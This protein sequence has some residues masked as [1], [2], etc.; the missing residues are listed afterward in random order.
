MP[1]RPLSEDSLQLIDTLRQALEPHGEVLERPM[2][3]VYCLFLNGKLCM[4][5]KNGDWLL[6]LDP[7]RHD[8]FLEHNNTRELSTTGGMPG[9]IWVEPHGFASKAQ[10]QWWLQEAL[11]YHPRAKASPARRT[12]RPTTRPIAHPTEKANITIDAKTSGKK[13]VV[14]KN[15]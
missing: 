4:G 7:A 13:Q 3:G 15:V 8:E 12:T 9:Y 11:A 1:A 5:V 10:W 2:F 14:W 6:R